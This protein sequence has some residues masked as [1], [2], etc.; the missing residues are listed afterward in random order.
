MSDEQHKSADEA[1]WKRRFAAMM[2]ARLSGTVLILLGMLL[3]FS[4]V[5]VE[6]GNRIV[7]MLLMVAGLVDLA[8]VPALL[9]K[10]WRQP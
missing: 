3:G 6:G 1:M 9:R 2:L 5:F 10:R 4:D 8:V 7:G